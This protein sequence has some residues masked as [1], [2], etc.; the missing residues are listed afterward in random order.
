MP[1][2]DHDDHHHD[3]GHHDNGPD[4]GGRSHDGRSHDDRRHGGRNDRDDAYDAH[5]DHLDGDFAD[6]EADHDDLADFA[7]FLRISAELTG[8][9]ETE[10]R[11]TGMAHEHHRTVLARRARDEHGL[12]HLW[13]V[14]A[15]PGELPSSARAHDQG[16][17]WRTFHGTPP[18]ATAPGYGS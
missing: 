17:M 3:N 6:Y 7:A 12:I 4:H 14:G 15:W 8:F 16:L 1:A 11:A 18:G 10:L 5:Q 2:N 9:D 13:Y